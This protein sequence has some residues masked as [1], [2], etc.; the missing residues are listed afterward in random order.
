MFD[1][2]EYWCKF[3]RKI[4]LFF[5]KW[6]EQF[7]KFSPEPVLKSKNWD[8]Y[9]VILSKAENV[10]ASQGS[11]MWWQWRMMQNLKRTWLVSSKLTWRIWQILTKALGILKNLHFNGLLLTKVYNVLAKKI[12]R[13]YVW[14]HRGLMQNL[15][16]NWLVISKITWRIWQTFV[17]RLKNSDFI[18][19]SKIVK[20][21]K[22]KNSTQPDRPDPVWKLYFTLEINE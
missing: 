1:D 8:F 17:H 18:L 12:Q 3:W 16:K 20:L 15:K 10:W 22:N 5:Q 7:G 14:L 19:E 4:D 2:T 9:W 13:S 6:H 11:Y 21:N